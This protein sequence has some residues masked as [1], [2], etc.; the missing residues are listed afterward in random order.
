[1]NIELLRQKLNKNKIVYIKDDYEEMAIR[2]VSDK[3]N[4]Y[5]FAKF[6]GKAE[7]SIDQSA[8]LVFEIEQNGD[9]ISKNEYENY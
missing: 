4:I 7:Y 5:V 1:M 3:G 2:I 6:K 9:E 8:K